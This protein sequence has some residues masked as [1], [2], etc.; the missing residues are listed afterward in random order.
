[1]SHILHIIGITGAVIFGL[2]SL[3]VIAVVVSLLN[4]QANG[5]NPFE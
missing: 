4:A 5:E 3:V 1:M 2:V